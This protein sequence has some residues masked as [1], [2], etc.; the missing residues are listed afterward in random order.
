MQQAVS[1]RLGKLAV[2]D[3][4]SGVLKLS[5]TDKTGR[6][7]KS[8]K[9]KDLRPM[10]RSDSEC[11][12]MPRPTFFINSCRLISCTVVEVGWFVMRSFIFS[13]RCV[14]LVCC[15]QRSPVAASE[16]ELV[17]P[18]VGQVTFLGAE[19]AGLLLMA[20]LAVSLPAPCSA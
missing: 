16:A 9:S 15:S 18:D 2:G 6:W 8:A 14:A 7:P 17:L 11:E 12:P 20:G 3:C 1:S 5:N 13:A 19:A 10:C 4:P